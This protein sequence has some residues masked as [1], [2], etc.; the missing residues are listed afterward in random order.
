MH[1]L[2]ERNA[3]LELQLLSFSTGEPHALA[4]QPR[5]VIDKK[6]L[7]L[8]A[9]RAEIEIVGD[10]LILLVTFMVW[11]TNQDI[12]LLVRWKTGQTHCVSVPGFRFVRHR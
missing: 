4:E 7:P 12:F 6:I 9:W 1:D 3:V 5:I 11:S 10:F 8:N 2:S